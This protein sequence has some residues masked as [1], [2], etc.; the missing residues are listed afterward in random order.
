MAGKAFGKRVRLLR[1]RAGLRLK[2]LAEKVETDEYHIAA[3]ERNIAQ[4]E[5]AMILLL[6]AAL[7]VSTGE[8][9]TGRAPKPSHL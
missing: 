3:W 6:A 5:K 2:Q 4:P 8:L 9:L 1:E 7:G